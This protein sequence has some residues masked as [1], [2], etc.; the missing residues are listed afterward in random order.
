MWGGWQLEK[1]KS[2]LQQKL[3]YCPWRLEEG[4][5]DKWRRDRERYRKKGQDREKQAK[6]EGGKTV[7]EKREE[8][9]KGR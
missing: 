3:A 4:R 2:V 9:R 8:K 1:Q 6:E 7:G 5:R